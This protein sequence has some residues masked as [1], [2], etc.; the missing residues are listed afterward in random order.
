MSTQ[1]RRH[2]RPRA[3]VATATA[4][5]ALSVL[6]ACGSADPVPPSPESTGGIEL[7]RADIGRAPATPAQAAAAVAS[8]NGLGADLYRRLAAADPTGNLVFSPSSIATALAMTRFGARGATAAEMDRVLH[9]TDPTALPQSMN[10]LDQVL[11]GRSGSFPFGDSTVEIALSTANSLWAQQ[12][13][14]FDQ[15]FLKTLASAYGAGV[16]TV[17]YQQAP[18]PARAAINAWVAQQTKDKITDLLAPGT[19]DTATR[20][21]LVNAIYLKAPWQFPFAKEL[22]TPGPF[23]DATGSTDTV[24]MMHLGESL[25]YA[26]GKGWQAVGLPFAG[27]GLEMDILVPDAG[28][29]AA[30]EKGLS[31]DRLD[32]MTSALQQRPVVLTLPKWTAKTS[33]GLT[34]ALKALG[35][36][37]AFTD[38]ADFSGMTTAERFLISDVVH[39]ATMTVDEN[40]TEAAAATAVMMAGTSAPTSQVTL[41]VDRPFLVVLRDTETG[42]VLFLGRVAQP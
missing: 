26:S 15:D 19:I 18:E 32:A 40:G 2:A 22:T 33:V 10:A 4:T 31:A 8:V 41:T 1:P 28:T 36:P 14:T 3:L 27:G 21:T 13:L 38:D 39:Q 23:T 9:V 24:P 16:R 37:T 29:V 5:A 11:A 42:A 7:V 34:A 17:D 35:M 6:T 25:P 12:G 20:L 30:F